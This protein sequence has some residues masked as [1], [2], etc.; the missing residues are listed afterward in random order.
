MV[1]VE[2]GGVAE[3]D[4]GG[5]A[6][7]LLLAIAAG[8]TVRADAG[9]CALAS[10][11]AGGVFTGPGYYDGDA[12]SPGVRIRIAVVE[13]PGSGLGG[14]GFWLLHRAADGFETMVDGREVAPLAAS[15]TYTA[16]VTTGVKDL[17]GNAMAAN[18]VWSFTTVAVDGTIPCF[19]LVAKDAPYKTVKDLVDAARAN[20]KAITISMGSVGSASHYLPFQLEKLTG[21][22]FNLVSM[23]SGAEAVTTMLGGHVQVLADSSL[24]QCTMYFRFYLNEALL[25][26]GM[27]AVAAIAIDDS[28][29]PRAAMKPDRR[30]GLEFRRRDSRD[31]DIPRG[32][33]D[34]HRLAKT[35]V[36]RP[37]GRRCHRSMAARRRPEGRPTGAAVAG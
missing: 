23:K 35:T 10:S 37:S 21:A 6:A 7:G 25:A 26:A 17:A 27:G 13:P 8:L 29:R 14:G 33:P 32:W 11:T 30:M 36:G 20:P 31:S 34:R 12:A 9:Q 1:G 15:A 3:P 19:M 4:A 18:R 22:R 28:A 24:V 16:N 5:V 2:A